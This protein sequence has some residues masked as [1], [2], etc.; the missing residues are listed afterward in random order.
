MR[1]LVEYYKA[2]F[3]PLW[4]LGVRREA[5]LSYLAVVEEVNAGLGLLADHLGPALRIPRSRFAI[6]GLLLLREQERLV[7]WGLGRLPV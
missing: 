3:F 7:L 5:G 2:Q 6:N 4:F 1:A